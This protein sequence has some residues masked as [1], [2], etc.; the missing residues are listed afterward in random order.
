[1]V[2]WLEAIRLRFVGKG[3]GVLKKFLLPAAKVGQSGLVEMKN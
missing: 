3:S 2:K 1:M